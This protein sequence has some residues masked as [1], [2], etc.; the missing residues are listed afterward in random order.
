[1]KR[2][3]SSLRTLNSHQEEVACCCCLLTVVVTDFGRLL[4]PLWLLFFVLSVVFLSV[5]FHGIL[6]RRQQRTLPAKNPR[7]SIMLG[8]HEN[9]R[10]F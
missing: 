9:T 1:M 6:G 2:S 7:L 5:L 4:Q 8:I 10:N 3:K